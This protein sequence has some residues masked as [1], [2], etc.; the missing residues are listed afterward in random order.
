MVIKRLT[1]IFFLLLFLGEARS[2]KPLIDSSVYGK[3]ADIGDGRPAISNNGKFFLYSVNNYSFGKNMLIIREIYGNWSKQTP[4]INESNVTFSADSRLA[5][6]I[7]GKD[8]LAILR[9][10]TDS[11]EFLPNV[12]SFKISK[13]SQNGQWIAMQL[14]R[15]AKK[16][17]LKNLS[18]GRQQDYDSV[19]DYTFRDNDGEIILQRDTMAGTSKLHKLDWIDPEHAEIKTIWVGQNAVGYVFDKSG[20]QLAFVVHDQVDSNTVNSIWYYRA[21]MQRAENLIND[22]DVKVANATFAQ[23]GDLH[24]D[25][26]S[27]NKLFFSIRV[28]AAK[29]NLNY[30]HEEFSVDVWNYNDERLQTRQMEE[31]KQRSSSGAAYTA[32]IHLDNKKIILLTSGLERVVDNSYSDLDQSVVVTNETSGVDGFLNPYGDPSYWL[33]STQTGLRKL[34]KEHPG[35]QIYFSP[36]RKYIVYWDTNRR[37]F[38]IYNRSNRQYKFIGKPVSGLLEDHT[39]GEAKIWD[40]GIAGWTKDD[41]FIMVYDQYDIWQLDPDGIKAPVNITKGYGRKHHVILRLTDMQSSPESIVQPD[42]NLVLWAFDPLTKDNGFYEMK[43][44]HLPELLTMGPF[45]YHL[46]YR[47]EGAEWVYF[48][49]SPIK[50]GNAEVYIVKRQAANQAPN[51]FAT[52]DFKNFRALSNLEPQKNY[53]WLSTELVTWKMPD[54]N[55][56]QGILYKPENFNPKNKYPVIIY[57]YEQL[58]DGLNLFITP[59][60]SNG[61]MDI[62]TYVSHGYLVFAPDIHYHLGEAS[63][64]IVNAV[65]SGAKMISRYPWVDSSRMAVHGHSFGGYDVNCLITHTGIFAAAAESAGPSDLVSEYGSVSF[66]GKSLQKSCETGQNRLGATLWQRPDRYINNSPVFRIDKIT[67]PLLIMQNKEDDAVPFFHGMELF[68]GLRRLGKK[69]WM[70]QYDGSG[71]AVDGKAATKDF[72]IRLAQFFDHYL[73]AAPPPRWMTEGVPAKEKGYLSKTD[74]DTSDNQP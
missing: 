41:N 3:W 4:G 47:S 22:H 50:A 57:M 45:V 34:L 69:A 7:Q 14:S 29:K 61:T 21:G 64:S 74:L 24:F 10:G 33:V 15:P 54:G 6:W 26:S 58:S 46:G 59:D 37:S 56:S 73:K 72:T 13:P 71:H 20:N 16:I 9:L 66:G 8:S 11:T 19:L 23:Y 12:L 38:I 1:I 42:K 32:S 18:T 53:N 17:I 30:K 5:L 62:P 65:V 70:L 51:Y 31:A 48:P 36:M 2:Q 44:G 25:Q 35:Y 63:R 49:F 60:W 67:T 52:G 55:P 40:F 68:T 27:D 39:A 28:A 43:T